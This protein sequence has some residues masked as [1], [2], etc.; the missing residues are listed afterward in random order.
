MHHKSLRSQILLSNQFATQAILKGIRQVSLQEQIA[1]ILAQ[2]TVFSENLQTKRYRWKDQQHRD[3]FIG[4]F[5]DT[6]QHSYCQDE[7]QQLTTPQTVLDMLDEFRGSL[8][9]QFDL[10]IEFGGGRHLR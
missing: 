5:Q 10:L 9:W 1:Q 7:G 2:K 8:R 6:P 3:H 4:F